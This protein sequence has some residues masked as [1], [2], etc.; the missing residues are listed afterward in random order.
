MIGSGTLAQNQEVHN[1]LSYG[2]LQNIQSKDEGS[3]EQDKSEKSGNGIRIQ[4]EQEDQGSG[5]RINKIKD[6]KLGASIRD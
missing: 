4:D 2:Y 5:A 3:E 1:A 6:Q